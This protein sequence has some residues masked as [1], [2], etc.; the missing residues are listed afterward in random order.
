VLD[1]DHGKVLANAVRWA[2][3]EEPFIT[4]IGAGQVDIAAWRQAHSMTVNLVNLN[5]PMTMRGSYRELMPSPEQIV[6]LRL[7][8]GVHATRV[9]LLRCGQTPA[10][11]E[12]NGYVTVAVPSILDLEMV[13]VDIEQRDQAIT[14]Q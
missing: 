2:T 3:D 5:N 10:W 13:A 1:V 8:D 12:R 4:V 9:Q 7:P 6:R 11:E 14:R